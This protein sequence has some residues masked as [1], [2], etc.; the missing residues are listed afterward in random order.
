MCLVGE[1]VADTLLAIGCVVGAFEE[2][3]GGGISVYYKPPGTDHC[4]ARTG[5]WVTWIVTLLQ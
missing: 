4:P 3:C 1:D 5:S 2:F